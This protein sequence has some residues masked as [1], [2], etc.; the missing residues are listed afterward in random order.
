MS[1]TFSGREVIKVLHRIGF[2]VDHQRGSHVF[3]HNLEK[4]ISVVVPDHKELKKGTL[5]SILK[6]AGITVEQLKELI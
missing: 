3:L 6:K 4:N 2:V 1:K 5:N